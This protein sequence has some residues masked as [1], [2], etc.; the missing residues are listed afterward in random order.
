[1]VCSATSGGIRLKAAA[2]AASAPWRGSAARH[3]VPHPRHCTPRRA[4]P[5]ST[6]WAWV[7]K[8]ERSNKTPRARDSCAALAENTGQ[9]ARLNVIHWKG[10]LAQR[11]G[12]RC[13]EVQIILLRSSDVCGIGSGAGAAGSAAPIWPRARPQGTERCPHGH[14]PRLRMRRN[15]PLT[16]RLSQVP[17]SSAAIGTRHTL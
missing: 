5:S 2:L 12:N 17:P 9:L 14:G 3:P 10:R 8:P 4:Q 13:S 1:M 16:T 11:Q 15:P 6:A 7:K